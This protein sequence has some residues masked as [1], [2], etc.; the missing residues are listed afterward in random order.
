MFEETS[1]CQQWSSFM[2]FGSFVCSGV[3]VVT[4]SLCISLSGLDYREIYQLVI[5][6]R[7]SDQKAEIMAGV[8]AYH[9]NDLVC[10][11]IVSLFIGGMAQVFTRGAISVFRFRQT[12]YN[13]IRNDVVP[14]VCGFVMKCYRGVGYQVRKLSYSPAES[15][16]GK[17]GANKA[18]SGKKVSTS[19]GKKWKDMDK[20]E[21]D[22]AVPPPKN[23]FTQ[24]TKICMKKWGKV[25]EVGIVTAFIILVF[26]CVPYLSSGRNCTYVDPLVRDHKRHWAAYTCTYDDGKDEYGDAGGGGHRALAV[27]DEGYVN[28]GSAMRDANFNTNKRAMA[29]TLAD[30]AESQGA[31]ASDTTSE[32]HTAAHAADSHATQHDDEGQAGH[33]KDGKNAGGHHDYH[34]PDN[35]NALATLFL[36]G[37]EGAIKHLFARDVQSD[38]R[39][40]YLYIS[41]Y[42]VLISFMVYCP[43]AMLIPGLAMPFGMF[44]PN[45]FMGA[46]LG[47]F[48]GEVVNQYVFIADSDTSAT[49]KLFGVYGNP[50]FRDPSDDDQPYF[51]PRPAHPGL[52]AICGAAAM[53]S[54]FTHMSIAIVVILVEASWDMELVIP[55]MCAISFSTL[56]TKLIHE[57]GFDEQLVRLKKVPLLLPEM[58]QNLSSK[59]LVNDIME[60]LSETPLLFRE[61][62]ISVII[63]ALERHPCLSHFVI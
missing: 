62:R 7:S 52:Y 61:S 59:L 11:A 49:S 51:F 18:G 53:L 3:A 17:G 32:P 58:D 30:S 13:V 44:I 2:T 5:F 48:A 37:E 26:A 42:W 14:C 4:S 10:I 21:R 43:C 46:A 12:R 28:I 27:N 6:E 16:S 24:Q 19:G 29:R 9:W 8:K 47:R 36:Q 40:P 35:F 60:P 23:G 55:L 1:G 38:S 50:H 31:A 41:S 34:G 20:M 33:A 15:S 56:I 63:E 57:E 22:I 39:E 54:G 25:F 45:L